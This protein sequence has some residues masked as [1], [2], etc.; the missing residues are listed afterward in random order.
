MYW[1]LR[2]SVRHGANTR[3]L[4]ER[5][6]AHRREKGSSRGCCETRAEPEQG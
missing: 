4:A 6:S 5:V 3:G 1:D 2:N